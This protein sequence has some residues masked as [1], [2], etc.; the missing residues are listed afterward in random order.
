M[1]D[2]EERSS[3]EKGAS[4][5]VADAQIL[6]QTPETAGDV[7]RQ[8]FVEVGQHPPN[9]PQ[10]ISQEEQET[11]VL[12]M[13]GFSPLPD[14]QGEVQRAKGAPK[15]REL[16]NLQKANAKGAS[17]VDAIPWHRQR[18]PSLAPARTSY[19]RAR[20]N[21]QQIIREVIN[22][23]KN[24]HQSRS[25]QKKLTGLQERRNIVADAADKL[26]ERLL[27][28]GIFHEKEEVEEEEEAA[29]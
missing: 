5:T 9:H 28:S 25:F 1:S 12:E 16:Q 15:N 6:H 24:P 18:K 7:D 21:A 10:D 14:N 19:Q 11:G 27:S 17:E 23:S 3:N 8:E 29:V 4:N 26:M 13:A 2:Q 20:D 22:L